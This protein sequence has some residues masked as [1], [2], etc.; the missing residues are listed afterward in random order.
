VG[1]VDELKTALDR[2]YPRLDGS[3]ADWDEVLKRA[4][5]P[6]P[7]RRG[8]ATL[9]V[10]AGATAVA[11]ALAL[12]APWRTETSIL[13]R[14][15]AAIGTGPVIHVV[16]RSDEQAERVD[17]ASGRSR[18]AFGEQELWW[19]PARGFHKIYR[20]DGKAYVDDLSKRLPPPEED[21]IPLGF[22]TGYRD[23]LE[24]GRAKVIGDGE[25]VGHKV[26]WIRFYP[27][28]REG[29]I[30][31]DVAVDRETAKPV[32]TRYTP[33]FGGGG[34]RP[35]G[36]RDDGPVQF[37]RQVIVAESLP[38]GRGN[39]EPKPVPS[40]L[41]IVPGG[42]GGSGLGN[43]VS[44]RRAESILGRPPLWLGVR[45]AGLS[46]GGFYPAVQILGS[47]ES[48]RRNVGVEAVYGPGL[49]PS[50]QTPWVRVAEYP[51]LRF[52]IGFM[53]PNEDKVWGTARPGS[54]LVY[55]S[56]QVTP[57]LF[58]GKVVRG[59][60]RRDGLYVRI[61]APTAKQVISAA[62]ALRPVR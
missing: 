61:A 59:Y 58:V 49:E 20:F 17:L 26:T 25:I 50:P 46:F 24:S 11:V 39:F 62:R 57:G 1:E 18:A 40:R 47:D 38:A 10:L 43:R 60:L 16:L 35:P 55:S 21:P 2:D 51:Q 19:D 6:P 12:I 54:V 36:Y 8:R 23:A 32:F 30:T 15:A 33:A 44:E 56:D 4:S 31:F 29:G 28:G 45:H 37:G 42:V 9:L 48:D 14:A 3:T 41:S 22:T 7:H 52:E 13:D 34:N 53:L 27:G 5:K